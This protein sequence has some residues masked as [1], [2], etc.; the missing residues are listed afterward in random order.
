MQINNWTAKIAKTAKHAKKYLS[1]R[2]RVERNNE[3]WNTIHL[4]G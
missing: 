3:W 1:I 4:F 2:R